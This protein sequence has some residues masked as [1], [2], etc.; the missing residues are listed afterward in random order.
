MAVLVAMFVASYC[1]AYFVMQREATKVRR[2]PNGVFAIVEGGLMPLLWRQVS[3]Q[4][5]ALLPS[6]PGR[7]ILALG[8]QELA[9]FAIDQGEQSPEKPETRRDYGGCRPAQARPGK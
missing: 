2:Q 7:A 3:Q 5:F 1:G 9:T 8:G 6:P 4:P